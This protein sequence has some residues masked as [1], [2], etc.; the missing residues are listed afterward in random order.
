MSIEVVSRVNVYGSDGEAVSP[1]LKQTI[2]VKSHW[3]LR[4]FVVLK[5]GEHEYTV[6]AIDL[7]AAINNAQNAGR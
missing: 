3:N 7:L 4:T 1:K 2:E 5:V 6:K